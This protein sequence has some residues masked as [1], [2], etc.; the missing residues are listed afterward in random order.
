MVTIV[1]LLSSSANLFLQNDRKWF[2]FPSVEI[3]A[4]SSSVSLNVGNLSR[5]PVNR[6]SLEL[7]VSVTIP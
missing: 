3:S 5:Y 1:Y 4:T 2:L 6:D 7:V